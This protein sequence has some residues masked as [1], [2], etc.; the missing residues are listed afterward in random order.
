ML[1]RT[2]RDDRIRHGEPRP[3]PRRTWLSLSS[4]RP[5][6][7]CWRVEGYDAGDKSHPHEPWWW[8][9]DISRIGRGAWAPILFWCSSRQHPPPHTKERPERE[10]AKR[11]RPPE[12]EPGVNVNRTR[13]AS[14]GSNSFGETRVPVWFRSRHI[15]PAILIS[16]SSTFWP[17][18]AE[19]I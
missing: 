9:W 2:L 12:G 4:C 14:N 11:R 1:I 10:G 6:P 7:S 17:K 19:S 15:N 16:P 18:G 5:R 13:F 3:D 8:W